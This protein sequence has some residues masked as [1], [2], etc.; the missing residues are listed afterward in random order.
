MIVVV[1][2]ATV[3]VLVMVTVSF[4]GIFLVIV[5]VVEG[6]VVVVPRTDA[7]LVIV[8]TEKQL[9][10]EESV[11]PALYEF[12]HEGLVS[13]AA[14]S[15]LTMRDTQVCEI[16]VATPFVSVVVD[17]VVLQQKSEVGLY[18]YVQESMPLTQRFP[19]LTC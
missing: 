11:A 7:V 5:V 4:P 16:L 8:E 3:A 2:D 14:A 19:L 1:E 17:V 6:V 10:A 13:V 15:R 18:V 12:K 9:Q